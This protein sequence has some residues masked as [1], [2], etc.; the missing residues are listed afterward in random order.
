MGVK[1]MNSEDQDHSEEV[2]ELMDSDG[3]MR[4]LP[5]RHNTDGFFAARLEKRA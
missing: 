5:Q 4:C 1:I 2:R 3:F